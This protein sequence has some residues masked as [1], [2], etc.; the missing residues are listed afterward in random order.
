LFEACSVTD[1]NKSFSGYRLSVE[2][3]ALPMETETF[4]EACAIF[5]Q[6]ARLMVVVLLI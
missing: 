1:I 6:L 3:T 4:P 2:I 5:N